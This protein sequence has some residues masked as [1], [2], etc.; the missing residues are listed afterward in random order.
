MSDGATIPALPIVVGDVNGAATNT[1][2]VAG[3]SSSD[4]FAIS[5]VAMPRKLMHTPRISP[6]ESDT[7]E[8]PNLR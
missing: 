4:K 1:G 7:F 3:E 5:H 6:V 2:V 8:G